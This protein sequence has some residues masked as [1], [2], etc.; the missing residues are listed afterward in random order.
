MV[1]HHRLLKRFYLFRDAE[2][3]DLEIL[4]ARC[5][6]RHCGRNELIFREG[7][8]AD[9]LYLVEF[10][11]VDII[12]TTA[13]VTVLVSV[14]S[15]GGFGEIGF[16][17]HGPRPASA[18]AREASH[19]VKIPFSALARTL[20]QRPTLGRV[21]YPNACAFLATRLR[22]SLLDLSFARELN[23]RHF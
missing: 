1:T 18:R 2:T 8:P 9:A 11:T 4:E 17:D 15:G 21:F 20:E 22:R 12:R 23:G 16:F 13:D 10:G 6:R 14:G 7:E 19:L 5:D 3:E